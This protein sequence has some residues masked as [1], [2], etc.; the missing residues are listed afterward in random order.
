VAW[1]EG[2]ELN[3]LGLTFGLDIKDPALKLPIAGRIGKP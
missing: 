1:E 3:A 2:V